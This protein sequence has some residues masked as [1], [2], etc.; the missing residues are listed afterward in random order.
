MIERT[1][2]SRPLFLALAEYSIEHG[3]VS[4]VNFARV[5]V[6]VYIRHAMATV[7][8]SRRYRLFGYLKSRRYCRP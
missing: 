2:Q 4:R 7:A 5:K 1:A 6:Y 3:A 8:K